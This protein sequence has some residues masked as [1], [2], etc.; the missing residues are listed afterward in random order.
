[1]TPNSPT[2]RYLD[3]G[4]TPNCPDCPQTEHG[5]DD[6]YFTWAGCPGCPEQEGGIRYA[7]HAVFE[8]HT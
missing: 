1:M 2:L 8:D 3:V 5:E 7:A 4:P 6:G